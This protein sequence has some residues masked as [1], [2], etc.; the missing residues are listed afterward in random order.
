MYLICYHHVQNVSHP[1]G[2]LHLGSPVTELMAREMARIGASSAVG[3]DLWELFYSWHLSM[4]DGPEVP[5]A[6]TFTPDAPTVAASFARPVHKLPLRR[7]RGPGR[8]SRP[9]LAE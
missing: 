2:P 4:L 5:Q 3:M 6:D 7:T 8:S 9:A 1:L